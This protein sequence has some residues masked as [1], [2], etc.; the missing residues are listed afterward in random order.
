MEVVEVLSVDL[1]KEMDQNEIATID[2]YR[3]KIVRI[4]GDVVD[5]AED[6]SGDPV[7]YLEGLNSFNKVGLKG[8]SR[9]LAGSLNRG[10]NIT[11]ACTDVSEVVGSVFLSCQD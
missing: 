1:A 6:F 7:V 3:N 9:G 2:R 5:I 11:A 8:F 4:T 10:A